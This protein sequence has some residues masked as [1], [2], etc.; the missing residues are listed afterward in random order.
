MGTEVRIPYRTLDGSSATFP[1][2]VLHLPEVAI[3]TYA[4][5]DREGIQG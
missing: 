5:I 2:L 3:G 1:L 4:Y